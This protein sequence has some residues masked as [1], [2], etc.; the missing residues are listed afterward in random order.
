MYCISQYYKKGFFMKIV[1]I[2]GNTAAANIAYMFNEMA[3]IYPITPSSQMAELCDSYGNDGKLN[4]WGNK[5]SVT[6]MQ[7]EA[8]VAGALHGALNAGTMAT[9][10]TSSQGLLLMIPNMYKIAGELLPCVM[11]VSARTIAT[12]A[13]SIFCDYS[14]IYACMKT[15]FNIVNCANV[16]EINDLAIACNLATY[17]NSTPF[18]CFFDGFRTSH[19]MNTIEQTELDDLK[20]II[21]YDD[22]ARFKSRQMS[23]SAPYCKGTNQNPDV[24][25]QNRIASLN[26]YK[27]TL[28]DIKQSFKKVE[29]LT[30]RKYDTIEY[31]GDKNAQNVV[32]CMGTAVDSLKKVQNENGIIQ[33]RVLKPFDEKTFIEKLPKNIKNLTIIERNLDTNGYDTLRSFVCSALQQNHIVCNI[34]SGVYGLGGK[35]FTPDM[36]SAVFENM[37]TGKKNY[38]TIG[39]I[40]DVTNTSLPIKEVYDDKYDLSMRIYG[41]GSDGSISASKST[42]KILSKIPAHYTQGYFEY[43]SKKSGSLTTSHIRFDKSRIQAPY[44][45]EKADFVQCNYFNYLIKYDILKTIKNNGT[46]LLNTHYNAQELNELLPN[47]VKQS[48]QKKNINLYTINASEIAFDAGLKN[49]INNIMQ[50]ASFLTN[51]I[52]DEKHAYT[53]ICENIK[54]MFK[55]KGEEVIQKNIKALDIVKTN[56]KKVDV[57][58]FSKSDDLTENIV[59]DEYYERII[60]PIAQL[61]GNDLAVSNFNAD[62][63]M[64]TNTSKSE[65]R[66]IAE[67]LPK[68]LPENCI[69]CG[70]CVMMCPHAAIRPVLFTPDEN[71]PE[72]FESKKHLLSEKQYRLQVSPLDCTGCGVCSEVCPAKNKALEMCP[73]ADMIQKQTELY[74]YSQTLENDYEISRYNTNTIQFLKPYFE[75][76]GA[77]AGCGET[78]YIKLLSQLYGDRL[79]IANA[80]GCSSIYG[81]T[82][83]VCPY[84]QDDDGFG[85]AW[86]NSLFEDNAEFGYGI[87]LSKKLA[88][89]QF[90]T[91]LAKL[92]FDSKISNDITA[93]LNNSENHE[94]NKKLYLQLQQYFAT[95][96]NLSEAEK[97]LKQNLMYIISPSVWIVG[98]D[99]WAYDIGFGGLDHVLNSGENINI[100][101]LDTE[102]YSNTGGQTSKS[103]PRGASAKFNVAGKKNKKKDLLSIAMTYKDVYVAQVVMG[104][105]SE[106]T[107]KAFKEAESY[108]GVSLI[109]AYSPCINHGYDMQYSQTHANESVKCGYNTL[110]RYDPRLEQPMQIDSGEPT[111]KYEDY[112]LSENRFKITSKMNHDLLLANEK[113]AKNRKNQYDEFKE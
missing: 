104:A 42:I 52:I 12:H 21:D 68:W 27:D 77:C 90:L 33:I 53:E 61:Q 31:F 24:F 46:L 13:L 8:G 64:P 109:V 69:Q 83:P 96:K 87:A 99:G 40:D 106:Q 57:H 93:F 84:A 100:L 82:Y 54:T 110:F 88:R 60:K 70:K 72:D 7:S 112:L 11:Y 76:S 2:D 98:G 16:Q 101:V 15:G 1:C 36:A 55:L 47:H 66:G 41:L 111:G 103:T 56:I 85:I 19:E 63:K 22:I 49:K 74:D 39:I 14:D 48:L 91:K 44:V 102:V 26:T 4:I 38:F 20:D 80:T 28:N 51:K 17:K 45:D 58:E 50:F 9:T 67:R 62:G 71:T 73:L 107:I 59:K 32:V 23:P 105:N 25:F 86:A 113:D 43:D 89:M 34:Y 6:Q 10:F 37:T 75:F 94:Q 92:T 79:L 30:G 5:L 35:E 29:K 3:V 78:P 18:I 65:K 95:A 81:G 108:S 97:Y